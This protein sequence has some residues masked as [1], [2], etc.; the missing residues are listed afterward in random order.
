MLLKEVLLS[1]VEE[2]WMLLLTFYRW[3]CLAATPLS[4]AYLPLEVAVY[5]ALKARFISL[6][7]IEGTR[8]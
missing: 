1:M 3:Q 4:S 8:Y 7:L 2:S 5:S 6:L